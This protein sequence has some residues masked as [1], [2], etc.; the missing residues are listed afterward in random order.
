MQDKNKKIKAVCVVHNETATGI[1]S[2]IPKVRQTI[3]NAS[4]PAMLL[5]D[6]VSSIGALPFKMDEWQVDVAVTGS[7]KAL[8]LPCGLG[9]VCASEKA[10]KA[11]ESAKLK[12]VYYDFKCAARLVLFF[13]NTL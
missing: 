1:T 2:D 8:S 7:Q 5:V 11:M 4:S 3:D 6:G 10:L 13:P 12:R 9:V